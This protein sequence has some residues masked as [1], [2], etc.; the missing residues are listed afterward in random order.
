M[1]KQNALYDVIIIGGGPAGIQAAAYLGGEGV[2]T[3]L[4]EK[5]SV[6][7]GQLSNTPAIDNLIG[8]NGG[9]MF[10]YETHKRADFFSKYTLE[11]VRGLVTEVRHGDKYNSVLVEQDYFT[12]AL[13]PTKFYHAPCIVVATGVRFLRDIKN[14]FPLNNN[15][16]NAS[17]YYLDID[18]PPNLPG[19]TVAVIGG[20]NSAAQHAINVYDQGAD[21]YMFCRSGLKC[22]E[23][24]AKQIKSSNKIQV[25]SMEVS[26]RLIQTRNGKFYGFPSHQMFDCIIEVGASVPNSGFLPKELLDKDGFIKTKSGSY[27]T[28][29]PGVFAI[30][31]VRSGNPRRAAV[32][33]GDG[34]RIATVVHQFINSPKHPKSTY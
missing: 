7:G 9:P 17:D 15:V 31:D 26:P 3:L 1:N 20:G 6:Y 22:S 13:E 23:Y 8:I 16:L 32:A 2:N 27:E 29:M 4:I 34:G 24:L 21:A 11:R 33:I 25:V 28:N 10:R 12:S 19:K 18:L 5:E 30:G 14:K